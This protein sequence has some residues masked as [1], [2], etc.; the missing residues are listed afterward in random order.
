MPSPEYEKLIET[1][2]AS[3]IGGL[4]PVSEIRAKWEKFTSTFMIAPDVVFEPVD[5]NGV[6]AEWASAPDSDPSRII[7]FFHG[8]GYNIGTIALSAGASFP[9]CVGGCAGE[10]SLAAGPRHFSESRRGRR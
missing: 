10:L 8:G 2:R 1:L 4:V 6:E 9:R 7:L 3:H 5:A